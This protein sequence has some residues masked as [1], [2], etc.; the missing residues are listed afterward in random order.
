M[1]RVE[2][3]PDGSR[4]LFT[5]SRCSVAQNCGLQTVSPEGGDITPYDIVGGHWGSDIAWSPYGQ[6]IA[7]IWAGGSVHTVNPDGSGHGEL[8][9]E[10]SFVDS[11]DWSPDGGRLATFKGTVPTGLK[12]LEWP[13]GELRDVPNG[14]TASQPTWSP[15]NTHFAFSENGRIGTMGTDGTNKT[16]ISSGPADRDPDWQT[17]DPVPLP[18]GYARPKAAHVFKLP[19]AGLQGMSAGGC[20]PRAW[21]AARPPVMQPAGALVAVPDSWNRRLKR[22]PDAFSGWANLRTLRGDPDTPADE[23]DVAIEFSMEDVRCRIVEVE[24]HPYPCSG[25]P[26]SDYLGE[27]ELKAT[28]RLTDKPPTGVR[29]GTMRDMTVRRRVTCEWTPD[30]PVGAL[31]RS[32]R[33][34]TR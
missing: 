18:P 32:T 17:L 21:A 26:L 16:L 3:F 13:S 34:L 8:L 30:D 31:A 11:L 15:D 1:S 25:G 2:W 24:E 19:R 23:A 33:A 27:V 28:I 4:I 29:T 9:P 5:A 6:P 20:Q 7:Y 10:F 12:I 22:A 14:Q